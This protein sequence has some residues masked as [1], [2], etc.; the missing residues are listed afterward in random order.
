VLL[1]AISTI[2]IQ[3]IGVGPI[4]MKIGTGEDSN[5]SSIISSY[6]VKY[7]STSLFYQIT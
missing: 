3:I 6:F 7:H 5:G 1:L 2:K 4:S